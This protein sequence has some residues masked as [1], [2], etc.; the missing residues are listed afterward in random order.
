MMNEKLMDSLNELVSKYETDIER[1]G[2]D[3]DSAIGEMHLTNEVIY[4]TQIGVYNR[5][6]KDLKLIIKKNS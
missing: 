4:K 1:L 5:A 6:V 2:Y 3:L